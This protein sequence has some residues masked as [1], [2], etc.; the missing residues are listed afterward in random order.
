MSGVS[1]FVTKPLPPALTGH[2][3]RRFGNP[4]PSNYFKSREMNFNET[5][6]GDDSY[7]HPYYYGEMTDNAYNDCATFYDYNYCNQTDPEYYNMYNF[8]NGQYTDMTNALE[9]PQPSSSQNQNDSDFRT[10]RT[11]PEPK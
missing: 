4:G 8:D 3:W 10:G 7:Y 11:N 2:D 9:A 6:D 5:A 1:H